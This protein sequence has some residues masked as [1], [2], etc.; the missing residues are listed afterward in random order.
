L[1]PYRG[2]K[3]KKIYTGLHASADEG[4]EGNTG[5]LPDILRV[6]GNE[7]VH[8][9]QIDPREDHERVRFAVTLP[10]LIVENRISHHDRRENIHNQLP[11]SK[12]P[13]FFKRE[14]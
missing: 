7:A 8:P 6:T 12:I 3:G 1:F 9:G 10:S 5:K 14:K 11:E 13:G 2:G 4:L